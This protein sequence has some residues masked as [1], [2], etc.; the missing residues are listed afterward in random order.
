[1][2]DKIMIK[3]IF[4]DIDGTLASFKTHQIPKQTL[5]ALKKL[6]QKGIKLFIATGRGK[7]GLDV[8][9]DL[10][11]NSN[12]H[13]IITTRLHSSFSKYTDCTINVKNLS[14]EFFFLLIIQSF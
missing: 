3:A 4:F 8:L 11:Q 6:Q 1:M 9:N 10:R 12:I 7:D 2:E 14:D 5:T 13:I